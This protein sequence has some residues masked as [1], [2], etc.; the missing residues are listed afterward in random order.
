MSDI[1]LKEWFIYS[2]H[3]LDF[4]ETGS[5][6]CRLVLNSLIIYWLPWSSYFHFPRARSQVCAADLTMLGTES[7]AS[8]MRGK[9]STC[10]AT[11]PASFGD[12]C[13]SSE[14][15]GYSVYTHIRYSYAITFNR[16]RYSIRTWETGSSWE[17]ARRWDVGA[18][19]QWDKERFHPHSLCPVM[20]LPRRHPYSMVTKLTLA[21]S[22]C[23]LKSPTA[24]GL[25]MASKLLGHLL[26]LGD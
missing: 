11:F 5:Q 26:C 13:L 9:H 4:F 2:S 20:C 15:F 10:R 19:R 21:S 8:G 16:D 24:Q 22:T 18:R 6:C 3:I 17:S 14:F 23:V 25:I 12:A 1:Q 7:R